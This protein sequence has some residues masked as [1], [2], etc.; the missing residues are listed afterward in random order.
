MSYAL[1]QQEFGGDASIVG[2]PVRLDG[3]VYTVI[4]VMP[5]DFNF[6]RRGVQLWTAM[7]FVPADFVDRNH[8]YLQGIGRLR[9]DVSVDAARTELS[10]LAGR[11]EQQYPKRTNSSAPA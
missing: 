3:E 2:R 11:L 1:W 6:P 9:R 10:M 7:R 8:N 5:R 4:G